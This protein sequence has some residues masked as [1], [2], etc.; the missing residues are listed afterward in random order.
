M[1]DWQQHLGS[2]LEVMAIAASGLELPE[3]ADADREMLEEARRLL[4]DAIAA[5][6]EAEGYDARARALRTVEMRRE[7]ISQCRHLDSVIASAAMAETARHVSQAAV[8]V[9]L[10]AG[11]VVIGGQAG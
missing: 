7:T 11:A 4:V 6:A 8:R 3:M 5:V 10:R 9:A 2:T 1:T